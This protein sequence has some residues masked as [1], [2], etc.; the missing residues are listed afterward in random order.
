[1]D[2]YGEVVA[3]KTTTKKPRKSRIISVSVRTALLS[4]NQVHLSDMESKTDGKSSLTSEELAAI[5][6]EDVLNKMVSEL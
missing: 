6:D 5:E 1:M 2:Y 4:Y 3:K